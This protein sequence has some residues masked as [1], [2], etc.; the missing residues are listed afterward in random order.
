MQRTSQELTRKAS[1]RRNR[2]Y[3]RHVGGSTWRC[4]VSYKTRCETEKKEKKQSKTYKHH[5]QV[6]TTYR[7]L[8]PGNCVRVA[9][10]SR[11]PPSS[12]KKGRAPFVFTRALSETLIRRPCRGDPAAGVSP[13]LHHPPTRIAPPIFHNS[14]AEPTNVSGRRGRADSQR[15]RRPGRFDCS[16]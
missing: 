16:C 5:I 2:A 3:E 7:S 6:S 10:A 9:P 4:V 1:D 12:P 15:F 8:A 14:T 13:P 11:P